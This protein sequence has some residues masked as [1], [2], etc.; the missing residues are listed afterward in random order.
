[1]GKSILWAKDTDGPDISYHNL[2]ELAAKFPEQYI[3]LYFLDSGRTSY[4]Q[5]LVQNIQLV[6]STLSTQFMLIKC[7]CRHRNAPC[8]LKK[9][10][11]K[12]EKVTI[13]HATCMFFFESFRRSLIFLNFLTLPSSDYFQFSPFS[14]EKTDALTVVCPT[15]TFC[16][17]GTHI[18]GDKLFAQTLMFVLRDAVCD[19]KLTLNQGDGRPIQA[20]KVHIWL[21][22]ASRSMKNVIYQIIVASHDGVLIQVCCVSVVY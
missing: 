16:D 11:K 7:I 9:K 10:K 1:M 4:V 5:V 22:T 13:I 15:N 6:L 2:Q 8:F 17:Y 20:K 3:L 12:K 21:A 19:L 18:N 14:E